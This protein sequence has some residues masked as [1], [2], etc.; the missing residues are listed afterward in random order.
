MIGTVI[1]ANIKILQE[2]INAIGVI[3]KRTTIA[4]L[5]IIHHLWFLPKIM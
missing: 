5:I 3:I 1:N 4:D 2:E